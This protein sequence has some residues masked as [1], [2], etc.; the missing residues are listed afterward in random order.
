SGALVETSG[1]ASKDGIPRAA[2]GLAGVLAAAGGDGLAAGRGT[3]ATRA[4]GGAGASSAGR[5]SVGVLSV[6]TRI[7]RCGSSAAASCWGIVRGTG[8]E[9][10]ETPGRSGKAIRG[11][12]PLPITIR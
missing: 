11:S 12:G 1:S 8:V 7:D 9:P 3:S 6:G 2:A 5:D 10:G 4:A